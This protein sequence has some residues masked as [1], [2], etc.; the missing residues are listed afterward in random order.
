MKESPVD[1]AARKVYHFKNLP[2]NE[3]LLVREYFQNKLDGYYVDVGANHPVEE[4]QTWHLEQ[5][6]WSD[7]LIEPLHTTANC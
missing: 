5:L 3:Q 4:S 7:L 6:G 1:F 2:Q